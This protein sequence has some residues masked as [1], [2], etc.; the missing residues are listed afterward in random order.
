MTTEPRSITH[1]A[2]ATH[3]IPACVCGV[4]RTLRQN[5]HEAWL[6]GGCVRDLLLDRPPKDYDIVTDAVPERIME[7]FP[8]TIAVGKAFGIITVLAGDDALP[9]EVA[10]FRLDGGYADG[11]HPDAIQ[12]ASAREDVLRRDFTLN[13]LLWDPD[14]GRILD[15]VGGYEDIQNRLIRAIGDPARR[16]AEDKLRMLRAIRFATTLD[17]AI[18][19]ATFAAIQREAGRLTQISAERIRQELFRLLT[20]AQHP[21]RALALLQ[22]SGLLPVILPEVSAMIGV[23][24]P[25]E[26]HPEG[27]VF[28]HT[29]LMLD[30]LP[31]RRCG[32]R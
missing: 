12:F 27:D 13:A 26:F 15:Y 21:G 20:E 6:V 18:E 23:E 5:G 31:P 24:Q 17:F 32:W 11:R 4:F 2:D 10:T 1:P 14:D 25:P 7:L 28:T 19:P 22:E 16:F 9:V 8:K 3:A 29:Q 30:A